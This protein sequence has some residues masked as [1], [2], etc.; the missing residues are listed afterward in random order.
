MQQTQAAANR[1][2]DD[3][4]AKVQALWAGYR[5]G[6]YDLAEFR[7][8]ATAVVA[9][10]NTAGV[11]LGDIGLAAEITRQLRRATTPL[12]LEPNEVQVDQDRMGDSIDDILERTDDPED[13]L[14]DW[15]GSEPLVTVANTVQTAM[16]AH[17]V[18]GWTR[19]LSG[20]SCPLCTGWAD[21]VVRSPFVSMVRH[22]G[23]DCI[24]QPVL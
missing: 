19:V 2:A 4:R 21:G 14:G 17:A 10:A 9:S 5:L 15:A 6:R 7:A 8:R 24:Q 3:T 18:G 23:C 1:L 13:Q 22:V 12:G 20:T 16:Q 11:A